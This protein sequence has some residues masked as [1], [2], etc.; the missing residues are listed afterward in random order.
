M[1]N[2]DSDRIANLVLVTICNIATSLSEDQISSLVNDLKKRIE[3]FSA[4]PDITQGIMRTLSKIQGKKELKWLDSMLTRCEEAL[5]NYTKNPAGLQTRLEEESLGSTIFLAGEI[6]LSNFSAIKPK[7]SLTNLLQ[8]VTSETL[9]A[10][11]SSPSTTIAV[12]GETSQNIVVPTTIRAHAFVSLGKF[13]L[14]DQALAKKCISL[15]VK[16]LEQSPFPLIRNNVMVV[17]GDLCVRFTSL[18]DPFLPSL[19]SRIVDPTPFVRKQSLRILSSLLREGFMRWKNS[20]LVLLLLLRST[21]DSDPVMA[22]QAKMC[23]ASLIAGQESLHLYTHFIETIFHLNNY[24]KHQVYN[25]FIFPESA[26]ACL[27]MLSG[28]GDNRK[29]RM[30]IYSMMLSPMNNEHKLQLIAKLTSDIL[31]AAADGTLPCQTAGDIIKD[32]LTILASKV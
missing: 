8:A 27:T 23:I 19:Y 13:C 21:V 7:T 9:S 31:S 15:F 30:M 28:G 26:S 11:S 14:N 1:K 24:T 22:E 16:E 6:I 25:Q 10:S 3:E 2:S 12:M 17:M 18:V 29:L 32:T 5:L 20:P 4:S